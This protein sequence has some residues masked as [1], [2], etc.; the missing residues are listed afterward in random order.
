VNTVAASVTPAGKTDEPVTYD[1][2]L[3][4][5]I[6]TR[7]DKITDKATLKTMKHFTHEFARKLWLGQ[8]NRSGKLELNSY[9]GGPGTTWVKEP[10]RRGSGSHR[11]QPRIP[12]AFSA[13]TEAQTSGLSTGVSDK[14]VTKVYSNANSMTDRQL[15]LFN[16]F[17][18]EI[19]GL[20]VLEKQNTLTKM[21]TGLIQLASKEETPRG[22]FYLSTI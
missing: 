6:A 19:T 2:V 14:V 21:T 20:S 5:A 11:T 18:A 7:H 17:L 8:A 12:K 1:Q 13:H 22:R 15:S 9:K 3:N 10:K 4:V 16:S